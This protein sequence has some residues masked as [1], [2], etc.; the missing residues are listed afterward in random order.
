MSSDIAS[1]RLNAC[2]CLL[3]FPPVWEAAAPYM[4]APALAAY[5]R[6]AGHTVRVL[7]ANNLFWNHFRRQPRLVERIHSRCMAEREDRSLS[8]EEAVAAHRAA[9]MSAAAFRAWF[10]ALS[11]GSPTYELLVRTFGGFRRHAFLPADDALRYHDRYFGDVSQ[12]HAS[13]SSSDL[14]ACVIDDQS[15]PWRAF[16]REFVLP[17]LEVHHPG[18]LGITI[19]APNQVVP[20]FA[21]AAEAQSAW[22][23]M[24]I[25]FG[26]PWVTH[27][28]ERIRNVDWFNDCGFLFVPFQ[29]EAVLTEMVTAVGQKRDPAPIAHRAMHSAEPSSPVLLRDLPTPDFSDLPL[30]DYAE[31]GHLPLMASRGCYWSECR[32]CSYPLLEP[33]YEVR[34][35]DTLRDSMS[36]LINEYRAHHV[37]FT[38]PSMSVALARRIA[39]IVSD[40]ELELTWGA[41]TRLEDGFTREVLRALAN[42]GCTVLHWGLESGSARILRDLNKGITHPVAARVLEN[43]AA[44]GIHSR[45]LMMYAFPDETEEDMEASLRFVEANLD[46]IGSVCWS[47]CTVEIETALGASAGTTISAQADLALGHVV[48]PLYSVDRLSRSERRMAILSVRA[49]CGHGFDESCH[50]A[51]AE[52]TD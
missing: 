6:R 1:S 24:P 30:E 33:R 25:V 43:A 21:I 27:L 22:P 18:I 50:R 46:V 47:R 12:S 3:V 14:R 2:E 38:D 7:D 41:F 44:V 35:S 20:A 36:M 52:V 49:A 45:L 9:D 51:S 10:S 5:L 28:R 15:N 48:P 19:A 17:P 8:L 23:E 32:F 42:G 16:A 40:N 34:N 11:I 4:A 13:T 29:G 37:P 39:A 31:P 26:G